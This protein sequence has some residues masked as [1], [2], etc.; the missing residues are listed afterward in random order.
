MDGGLAIGGQV[1]LEA[2]GGEVPVD[3]GAHLLHCAPV[4]RLLEPVVR[5]PADQPPDVA[6]AVQLLVVRLPCARR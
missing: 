3:R 6:L 1:A 2:L 4:H 5:V